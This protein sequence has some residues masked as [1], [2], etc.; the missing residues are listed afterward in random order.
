MINYIINDSVEAIEL[1]DLLATNQWDI[2]PIDKLIHCLK[3][4]W[5]NVCAR[6]QN[7]K[8]I[9]YARVLSDGIRHAYIC[10]LI[11]HPAFRKQGIGKKMM[12]ELLTFLKY[13]N[14]YPTLVAGQ[15]TKEYY[16]R[17]GF[18]IESNGYTAMCIRKPYEKHQS[19]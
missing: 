4:S 14:L 9:G 19:T 12:E 5:C 6:D 18:E 10:S 1:N 8:L 16:K 2:H 15:D 11:V 13:N 3:I 17:F 7:S